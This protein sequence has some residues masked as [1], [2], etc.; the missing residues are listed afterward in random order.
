MDNPVLKRELTL[1][2]RD[3]KLLRRLWMAW[4]VVAIVVA[5]LWPGAGIY[6]TADQSQRLV[7]KAFAFGQLLILLLVSPSVSAPLI[8]EEKEKN[9]FGMLFA[10]LLSPLDILMGK[11]L[12]SLAALGLVVLSGI[13]LLILTLALGGVSLMEVLQIYLVLAVT[14]L[15]FGLLGLFFSCLRN[16]TYHALLNSYAWTLILVALTWLPA[17]L[18]GGIE[19]LAEPLL[20]LR[21]LSPFAAMMDVAAP[22]LLL[23]TGRLPASWTM[24]ELWTPDLTCYLAGG[25]LASLSLFFLCWRRVQL[26]PLGNDGSSEIKEEDAK[27]RK[28]PYVLFNPDRRRSAFSVS[29]LVFTK[30]LRCK[31][32]GYLGNLIR[33]IY[34]GLFLSIIIVLLVCFNAETLSIEA[35]RL[36]SVLFPLAIILL[37]TPALTASTVAEEVVSGTLEMLRLTPVGSW[38]FFSGKFFAGIFYMSILLLSSSPIY[39]L[40]II[41]EVVFDRDP[42]VVLYI[43]GVQ[44]GFMITCATAGVWSSCMLLDTQKATGLAYALLFALVGLPFS[45]FVLMESGPLQNWVLALSPVIVCVREAGLEAVKNHDLFWMHMLLMTGIV[46]LLTLH[47]LSRVT[48][49]MRQAT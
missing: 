22:E 14:I 4:L 20:M 49:L 15:E 12:S 41:W 18:L 33:G 28:F 40:F 17:Y 2:L 1:L 26:L 9:R 34:A 23:V 48:R 38:K 21:S 37:M 13:P 7:F 5:W 3:P 29:R 25:I 45:A 10:S 44:A 35:T 36:V 8:T 31:L 16:K 39:I 24:G 32:F 19:I 47:S 30:E 46:T 43:M 42:F 27:K 6:S 11:W